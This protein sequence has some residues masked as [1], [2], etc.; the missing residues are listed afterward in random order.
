MDCVAE[1]KILIVEDDPVSA[2]ALSDYLRAHGFATSVARTGPEGVQRFREEHPDLLLVDVQL[3]LRNGFEVCFDVRRSP[4]GTKTPIVLMS[5]VYTD[6]K[7]AVPYAKKSLGVED[8]LLKP[9]S[10]RTMLERVTTLLA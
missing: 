9:F 6:T 7:H 1:K 5:A 3:P 4:G 10:M 8:Y 2:Q